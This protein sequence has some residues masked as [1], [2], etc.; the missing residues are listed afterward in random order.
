VWVWIEEPEDPAAAGSAQVAEQ[1]NDLYLSTQGTRRFTEPEVQFFQKARS[2]FTELAPPTSNVTIRFEES[3]KGL[4]NRGSWRNSLAVADM[5]N[6]GKLDLIAPPQRG[7]D[8]SPSIFLG[9]GQ[10]NWKLWREV[11]WPRALAYGSVS[12]ADFNRDGNMDLAFGVHLQG[13]FVFLGDGKGTFTNV[14]EGLPRD[15]PTRRI[16]LDDV[17]A[18]GYTDIVGISEGPTAM[19][20][21]MNE[22]H[23][24]LRVY[25]NRKN[26]T[27]WEGV[28]AVD[29]AR[30]LAGDHLAVGRFN[31]DKYPDFAGSSIYFNST[32][33]LYLSKSAREWVPIDAKNG[34]VVPQASY[35][36]AAVAGKFSSPKRDDAVVSFVRTWPSD[37][38]PKLVPFPPSMTI[39]GIDRITFENGQA[40]RTSIVRW[41]GNDGVWGLGSGDFN[42]D[43]HAD[44]VYSR[45]QPREAVLLLND[46]KGN[47]TRARVEGLDLAPKTNYDIRVADVNDDH[48]PDVIVMYESSGTTAF[49]ERTGAIQVFLNRGTTAAPAAQAAK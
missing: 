41:T 37:L 19:Q 16:V 29:P 36:L 33:T 5:N 44:L 15:F 46:G 25:Y 26:G 1:A 4:P 40:K 14:N 12:A 34:E 47:F 38:N 7:S 3:S 8:V 22:T 31:N 39:G 17:D 13:I 49:A 9:D 45:M 35:Y 43:G 10:G 24:R 21:D 48:R 28:N 6:D 11:K 2:E 32:D 20:F 18:D 27:V 23:S 30:R 42:G